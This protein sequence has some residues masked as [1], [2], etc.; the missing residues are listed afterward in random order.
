M[1]MGRIDFD[2]GMSRPPRPR[3]AWLPALLPALLLASLLAGLGLAMSCD[4]DPAASE[5][6]FPIP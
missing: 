3:S 2:S 6:A 1:H 4:A 5:A